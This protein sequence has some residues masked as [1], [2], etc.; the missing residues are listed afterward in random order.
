M[1]NSIVTCKEIYNDYKRSVSESVHR[2]VS[3]NSKLKGF[4]VI[5]RVGDDPAS[6]SYIKGK[7][8]DCKEVGIPVLV[9][10]FPEDI[11]YSD[12]Y[13]SLRNICDTKIYKGIIVQLPIPKR[14]CPEMLKTVIP[15]EKDIDGIV[16]GSKF[17][18]CT[19]LGII[20][21]LKTNH[22]VRGKH[23]VIINRSEIVGR[24]LV[25]MLLDLDATVTVCHSKTQNIEEIIKQADILIVAVGKRNFIKNGMVKKDCVIIDVGINR[26]ENGKLCGDVAR[27]VECYDIT[28][29][30]GGVGLLTRSIFLNNCYSCLTR[31]ENE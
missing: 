10:T 17:S 23:C 9:K 25:N 16:P 31:E 21:Y 24:P 2:Y 29:V 11:S 19:P 28:P 30:P 5:V 26:D 14:L 12:F 15:P 7:L 20:E 18:P 13:K 6:A 27:D 8:K 1:E 3:D 4:I 22:K